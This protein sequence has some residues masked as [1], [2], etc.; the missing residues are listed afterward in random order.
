VAV[1]FKVPFLQEKLPNMY[2]TGG[3]RRGVVYAVHATTRKSMVRWA[4]GTKEQM[5]TYSRYGRESFLDPKMT[6]EEQKSLLYLH[7]ESRRAT[8]EYE[9]YR[10]RFTIELEDLIQTAQAEAVKALTEGEED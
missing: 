4:D 1:R 7:Q 2:N 6:K 8:E 3:V 5:D 9:A 10:N